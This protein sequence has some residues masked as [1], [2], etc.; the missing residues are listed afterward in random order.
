MLQAVGRCLVKCVRESDTVSRQGGDEFVVLLSEMEHAGYAATTAQRMLQQLAEVHSVDEHRLLLT[1]SIG[2]G[3]YP[4]DG[5]DAETLVRNADTAMYQAK[6]NGR[7]GYQC[8]KPELLEPGRLEN[9]RAPFPAGENS[10]PTRAP[11]EPV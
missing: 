5:G 1:A 10:L 6:E 3:V 7:N 8:F 11:L 9:P 2:V 4:D